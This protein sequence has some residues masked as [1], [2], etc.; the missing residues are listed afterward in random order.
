[1]KF[2]ASAEQMAEIMA[3]AYNASVSVGL[4]YLSASP[5][6]ISKKDFLSAAEYVD[7]KGYLSLDYV[8][9]RMVKLHMERKDGF[10]QVPDHPPRADY[11]SWCQRYPDYK[12]L[13]ET[14]VEVEG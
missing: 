14:V 13:I 5:A 11:Q 3:N 6:S 10:W 7:E 2:K 8:Q 4:G 1:M 12:A 9:G